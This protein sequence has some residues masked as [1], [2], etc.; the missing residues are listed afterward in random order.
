MRPARLLKW[1]ALAAAALAAAAVAVLHSI[2]V[3]GYR[4]EI[5]AQFREATGRALTID[6]DMDLSISLTPAI[7]V[8]RVAVANAGRGSRPSLVSLERAEAEV[9]LLPLLA[10]EVRVTRLVLIEPDIL[11][12]T[13]A[14]GVPNWRAAPS[15]DDSSP[16]PRA[17]AAGAGRK[18][19][20]GGGPPPVPFFS[21]IEIRRGRLTYRDARTGAE[22]RLDLERA[23]ARA[24]SFGAPLEIDAGGAWNGAPFSVTGE[25]GS[26]ADIASGRPAQL[27]FGA[28]LASSDL[29]GRIELSLA[30]PRPRLTGTLAADSI[31]LGG[32]RPGSA[33]SGPP[34]AAGDGAK[35]RNRRPGRVFPDS[36]LPLDGLRDVD[37]DLT[38]SV[39][40]L[41]GYSVPV[42]AVQARISLEDGALAIEP[43]SATVAG[44]PV[45]GTLGLDARRAMPRLR[46]A[47]RAAGFDLG[48]LLEDAGVTGLFEGKA[49]ASADLAGS[50]RSVAA[51]MAG[52]DGDIR[53][54]GGSGRLK[55][56]AVGGAVA[57]VL[58]AGRRQWTIVNCAV[59]SIGIEK[60]RAT[61]RVVRIDTE[62]STVAVK[63]AADLASET[64]DLV[65]PRAKSTTLDVAVPVRVRGRFTNPEFRP[66]ADAVLKKLGDLAW[67]ASF[68]PAAI[69]G[70]AELGGGDNECL[71][72]ATAR[73]E[74]GA[75]AQPNP[76]SPE[77]AVRQLRDNLKDAV[78]DIG[79]GLKD[80]FRDRK[81]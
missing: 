20:A 75:A 58:L 68:S 44:S 1:T 17:S 19:E 76:A 28:A 21:H 18:E 27:R 70:L 13:D 49:W 78:K 77:K 57:G 29:S 63:G 8:E 60:G 55:T 65:E 23:S 53:L 39:E 14:D 6:G 52:L 30:G 45:E 3:N 25:V 16:A 72:A 26:L 34:G 40:T 12:E 80:L 51:L 7:V 31:D 56:A 64:F 67:V 35:E 42:G 4:D 74:P 73:A 32:L 54:A 59:A 46:L 71:K 24:E 41:T 79:R 22:T 15:S 9:A 37:L 5:A 36:P 38:L 62:Y 10:G 43:F 69:A 11:L 33:G 61:S 2:D 50:G 48:R 81:D 66:G 47:A